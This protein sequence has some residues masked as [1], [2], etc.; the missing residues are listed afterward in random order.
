VRLSSERLGDPRL[1]R[2]RVPTRRR[3]AGPARSV[4]AHRSRPCSPSASTDARFPS[5]R[6]ARATRRRCVTR[7]TVCSSS[8]SRSVDAPSPRTTTPPST[9]DRDAARALDQPVPT[10]ASAS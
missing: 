10:R 5:A 1:A 6:G 4:G 3:D 8:P 2:G 9:G 7:R